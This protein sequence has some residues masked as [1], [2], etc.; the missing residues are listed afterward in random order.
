MTGERSIIGKYERIN[1]ITMFGGLI[2]WVTSGASIGLAIAAFDAA[3][4]ATI[5]GYRKASS[6]WKAKV[7]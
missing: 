3:Q 1:W 6:S 5:R 7:R 2:A 4:I